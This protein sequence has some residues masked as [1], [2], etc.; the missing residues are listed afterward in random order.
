MCGRYERIP[1]GRIAYKI[2]KA[3][4]SALDKTVGAAV[5]VAWKAAMQSTAGAKDT[6]EAKAREIVGPVFDK[7]AEMEAHVEKM[8]SGAVGPPLAKITD[9]IMTPLCTV[10]MGPLGAAFKEL[11]FGYHARMT[12]IIA[13]G[14]TESDLRNFLRDVRCVPHPIAAP[15]PVHAARTC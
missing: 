1:S 5:G 4:T 8:I 15:A 9:P 6:L 7:Q 13:D 12:A 14:I 3:V 11:C 2:R 10:L